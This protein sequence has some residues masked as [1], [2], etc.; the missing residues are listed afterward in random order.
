MIIIKNIVIK[1][2][3]SLLF[4]EDLEINIQQIIKFCDIIKA[5]QYYNKVIIVC[6]GGK[7]ARKYISAIRYVHSNETSNDIMGIKI[8]RINARLLMEVIGESAF[9][10]VPKQF[11]ELAQALLFDKIIIMGGLQP[12]QSTTSVALEVAEFINADQVVIL[13]NVTGIYN[14]DPNKFDDAKLIK[15]LTLD[16]LQNLIINNSNEKQAAA[17]EYRIFDAV[18]L[19]IMK[20]SKIKVYVVS[21]TNLDDFMKILDGNSDFN[22]TLISN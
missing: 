10:I 15:N 19:Q 1:I 11:E 12:G 16:E 20:R 17:G 6:G 13:T 18:S 4:S 5:N 22:G 9:P 3:G 7:I 14:K 2:G 21:G 8:S